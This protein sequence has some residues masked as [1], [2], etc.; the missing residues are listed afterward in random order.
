MFAVQTRKLANVSSKVGV[1]QMQ[2]DTCR[3]ALSLHHSN[4]CPKK[5]LTSWMRKH[6]N[7]TIDRYSPSIKMLSCEKQLSIWTEERPPLEGSIPCHQPTLPTEWRTKADCRSS[8]WRNQTCQQWLLVQLYCCQPWNKMTS[9][10]LL[11]LLN[12]YPHTGIERMF[13]L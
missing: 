3:T 7:V 2:C 4:R 10:Y 1:L 9:F 13:D 12:W 8:I 5:I 11:C 6:V